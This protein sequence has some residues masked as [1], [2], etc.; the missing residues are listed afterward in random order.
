M[1]END[2]EYIVCKLEAILFWLQ[3]VIGA[4]RCN[5]SSTLKVLSRQGRG[6]VRLHDLY[7]VQL[8]Y[9][10]VHT[11]GTRILQVSIRVFCIKNLTIADIT[12]TVKRSRPKPASLFLKHVHFMPLK[13]SDLTSFPI[14]FRS[15]FGHTQHSDTLRA[16]FANFVAFVIFWDIMITSSNGS[17]LRVTGEFPSQRPVTRN[18]DAFFDLR[19]NKRLS[20]HSRRRWF[21]APLLMMTSL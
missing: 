7:T 17:I 11:A 12:L 16:F 14:K 1:E 9:H 5:T 19:L 21:E 3:C 15:T 10:T 4:V 13:L 18:F 6:R 20:Q 2:F 8:F